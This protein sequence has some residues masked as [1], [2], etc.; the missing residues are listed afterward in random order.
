MKKFLILWI[1][2]A[3]SLFGSAV[4]EFSLA[5]YLTLK[6][7]SATVLA[8]AMLVAFLPQIFLGPFIGP[9]VDRWN[10]K[11]TMI[12]AD[13]FISVITLILVFLFLFDIIQVWHIYLA[14]VLRSVG[15]SI[16]F[17]AMQAA[18]SM[19][20]PEKYLSRSAGLTQMLQGLVTI[21]GPPAGALFLGFLPMQNVLLIDII[22]FIIAVSII[23]PMAIPNPQTGTKSANSSFS[24]EVKQGFRYIWNWKGLAILIGLSAILTALLVPPFTL[25]PILVVKHLDGEVIKLGWLESAFGVGM[26]AGGLLLGVWAG[27]KRRVITSLMGVLISG[28]STFGLGFTDEALFFLGLASSFLLGAGISIANAPIMAVLQSV[29]AK[30]LQG[31]I[32]SLVGSISGIMTPF[33]LIIAGPIADLIGINLL[34]LSLDVWL[35]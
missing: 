27:F 33:G 18:T 32:F 25:L 26:I 20:V 8:T 29:V 22:T 10:R 15:Q 35:F 5:W 34:F 7:G 21:F 28:I 4:V 19:I 3:F 6:T 9:L 30:D 11:K 14:M 1:S 13:L 16:H 12:L 31:R 24:T 23:L 17:P 2:Q